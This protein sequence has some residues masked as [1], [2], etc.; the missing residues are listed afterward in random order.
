MSPVTLI[1]VRKLL[2]DARLALIAVCLVLFSF[3]TLWVKISQVVT[4]EISPAFTAVAAFV[5]DRSLFKDMIFSGPGKVS[6]AA[7]GWGHINFENPNDFLAM[8]MLHPIMLSMCVLWGVG[9]S[10]AAV[11]GELD[12]GTMELLLSQPVP[13]HTL[14]VAHLLVDL[15]VLP[16]ICL[17]FYAGTQFGLEIVGPFVPNY[18]ALRE[19]K[20]PIPIPDHPEPLAVNGLLEWRG[21]AHTFAFLLALSGMTIAFSAAGR[22]RWRVIGWMALIVVAM[23]VAN[24][25]GQLWEPARFTR[26]VTLFFYYQPQRAMLNDLWLVDL[27]SSWPGGPTVPAIVVLSGVGLLGYG[28]ALWTFTRRDLPAPL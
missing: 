23:F 9:R 12:R 15:I 10:A 18:S 17:S 24:T 26:P 5:G 14:I 19:A 25:V 21:L 13:R 6:E 28:F 4:V 16:L 2:R 7:L 11:A 3:A 8:G 27:G 20:M 1:L 22:S